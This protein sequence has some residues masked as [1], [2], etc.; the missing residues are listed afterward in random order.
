V[1]EFFDGQSLDSAIDERGPLPPGEVI[2]IV[3]EAA[4]ALEVAH[5]AG[6]VHRDLKPDN[7]MLAH[8]RESKRGYTVK[9][10]DF[11]IAKL[12]EDEM[13]NVGMTRAGSVVGTPRYM[14]PEGLTGS[15]LVGP[16]SDLWALGAS[17]F[18]AMV[19]K[20]PFLGE[21]IGDI[22]LS[23]CSAPLPAP[24]ECRPGLPSGFD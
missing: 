21:T 22:V 10:V 18:A 3:C 16:R 20:V 19:G 24:S 7:I 13:A 9:L 11:G 14:S 17:A 6:V 8:D 5:A 12:V 15:A 2:D 1:M 23:V 4:V